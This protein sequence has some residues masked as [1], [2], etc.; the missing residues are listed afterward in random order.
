M[1]KRCS[2]MRAMAA[3]NTPWDI[4]KAVLGRFPRR[5]HI[6]LP[7]REACREIVKIHTLKEG[8]ELDERIL[9]PIADSCTG[10]LFAGRDIAVLCNDAIWNMVRSE[11]PALSDL[12]DKSVDAIRK[13]KLKTRK[14]TI[15]DFDKAFESTEGAVKAHDLEK[16]DRWA[17]EYGSG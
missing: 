12:A 4:D 1:L 2:S 6:P 16:Y 7:D 5:V 13:Y 11:N 17:K 10:R 14:L 8:L 3:T 15:D 9:D